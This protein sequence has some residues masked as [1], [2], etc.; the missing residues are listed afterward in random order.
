MSKAWFPLLISPW[1]PP[2]FEDAE[3]EFQQNEGSD[4]AEN[5]GAQLYSIPQSPDTPVADPAPPPAA[6]QPPAAEDCVI[7]RRRWRQ[8]I[9]ASEGRLVL[10]LDEVRS[11]FQQVV[12]S[13][14]VVLREGLGEVSAKYRI[15]FADV[16]TYDSCVHGTKFPVKHLNTNY[17]LADFKLS[18][19][20]GNAYRDIFAASL[21]V[22]SLTMA[23]V[24]T[25]A[26]LWF[27]SLNAALVQG[28]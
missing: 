21:G 3:R 11:E 9:L 4:G 2:P 18:I 27:L 17:N 26:T 25:S 15:A 14:N 19:F 1:F 20:A 6:A 10:W 12:E 7:Q 5:D 13:F 16:E 24:M 23:L 28:S 8:G 22:L